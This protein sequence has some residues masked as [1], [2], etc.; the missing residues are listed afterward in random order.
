MEGKSVVSRQEPV[1]HMGEHYF[2][3]EMEFISH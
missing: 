2:A 1:L 3:L